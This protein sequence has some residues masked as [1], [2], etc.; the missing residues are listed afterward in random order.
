M[1]LGVRQARR[2]NDSG[3]IPKFPYVPNGERMVVFHADLDR[4]VIFS[5][6][7]DIG[8]DKIRVETYEGREISFMTK[9]AHALLGQVIQ[10]TLFVPTTTR[11]KEQYQRIDFGFGGI[12]YALVCNGG[13]LLV[14]GEEDR[15]WYK[16]SLGLIQDAKAQL[17][18]AMDLLDKDPRRI[19]ELR[20]LSNLFVFTKCRQPGLAAGDLR[21]ALDASAVDV[22]CNGSKVYVVPKRLDKGTALERF[23]SYITAECVLAA[24]DSE[25]DRSMLL[26]ADLSFA[27][28]ERKQWF[29]KAG[30]VQIMP[31]KGNFTEEVLQ[32][33]LDACRA[34]T[35]TC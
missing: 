22:F 24:G 17:H 29:E 9:K 16:E 19:F 6:K 11:T 2:G 14:N 10:E 20:F 31:G 7:Q 27:P 3:T 35:G 12:K 34:G 21:A 30:H 1:H 4:T 32:C 25:F 13:I 8:K 5:Y 23:R 26:Q 15:A 28:S 33:V 18:L